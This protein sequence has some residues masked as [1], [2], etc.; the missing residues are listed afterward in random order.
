MGAGRGCALLPWLLASALPASLAVPSTVLGWRSVVRP[1]LRV[2]DVLPA[3]QQALAFASSCVPPGAVTLSVINRHHAKMRALQFAFLRH[4]PCFMRRMVSVC[5]N[6]TDAFGA[7]V[8]SSFAIPPSDFKRSHYANLIWA[9]WRIIAH[10]LQAARVV[11]WVDAD[12]LLLR[13]PW[14]RLSWN[15][16][17]VRYDIRYQSEK[18]CTASECPELRAGCALLNGGQ[19]L[20]SSAQLARRIYRAR[21]SNLTNT[22]ELDQDYADAIIRG[23][24]SSFSYCPLPGS[25][26]A[27]C[28]HLK[29]F[30][31][32]EQQSTHPVPQPLPLCARVTH[33]FNCV[34]TRKAKG[35]LMR[36]MVHDFSRKC[37]S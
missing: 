35:D 23:N 3:V 30:A 36:Q 5:Y 13:N 16:S 32:P 34:T 37:N 20:V 1:E 12:V 2:P 17:G 29:K 19:L 22:A 11:L 14:D 9:K 18:R 27:Q 15:S 6:V 10:A 21:P 26:F 4:R 7:C 33:H 31:T 25:Y 24:G 8:H 28:W